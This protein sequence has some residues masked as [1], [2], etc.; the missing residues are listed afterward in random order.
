[1]SVSTR[2]MA[3][4]QITDAVRREMCV[5]DIEVTD[6]I[7][8]GQG[9]RL[10]IIAEEEMRSTNGRI[11]PAAWVFLTYH[12]TEIIDWELGRCP[13]LE[14][15]R[16]APEGVEPLKRK[17]MPLANAHQEKLLGIC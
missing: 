10:G 2:S 15:R 7:D 5:R 3:I 4:Q 6:V 11:T 12:N 17:Y 14:N 8:L 9:Y 13:Y 16:V 1:M